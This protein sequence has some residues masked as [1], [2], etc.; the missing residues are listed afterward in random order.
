MHVILG[1][2]D[3]GYLSKKTWMPLTLDSGIFANCNPA[4]NARKH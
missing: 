3:I 2:T 4:E 1:T